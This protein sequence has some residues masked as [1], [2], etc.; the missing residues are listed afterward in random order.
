MFRNKRKTKKKKKCFYCDCYK[1][2][3]EWVP[4]FL[5]QQIISVDAL[6]LINLTQPAFTC[7][8]LTIETLEQDVKYV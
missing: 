6:L 4:I 3:E 8:E 2:S 1:K 7:S 5:F